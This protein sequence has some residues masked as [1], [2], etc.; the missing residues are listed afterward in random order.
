M[1]LRYNNDEMCAVE[2]KTNQHF[3]PQNTNGPYNQHQ[4]HDGDLKDL[5]RKKN[6]TCNFF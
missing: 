3:T 6:S 4:K 2:N 1:Y 5:K